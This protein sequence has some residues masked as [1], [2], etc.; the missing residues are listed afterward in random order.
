LAQL[1]FAENILIEIAEVSATF[2]SVP[3]CAER[4]IKRYHVPPGWLSLPLSGGRLP[5]SRCYMS[6][7]L[8]ET[9]KV[10][11]DG[12]S[13]KSNASGDDGTAQGNAGML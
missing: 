10:K 2:L 6:T 1:R 13:C 12:K 11:I 5:L 7:T 3:G 4:F 8:S 9:A